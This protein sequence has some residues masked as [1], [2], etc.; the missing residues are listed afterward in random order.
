MPRVLIDSF[1]SS[2]TPAPFLCLYPINFLLLLLFDCLDDSQLGIFQRQPEKVHFVLFLCYRKSIF[3]F[4]LFSSFR[5]HFVATFSHSL[6]CG[7]RKK[8]NNLFFYPVHFFY[9][10][11]LQ[12]LLIC[13][14]F[15]AILLFYVPITFSTQFYQ[16]VS[17]VLSFNPPFLN[18]ENWKLVF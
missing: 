13:V 10:L 11:A 4:S 1:I 3:N 14:Y 2:F 6:G 15:Q 8:K 16:S 17:Y 12:K 7:W 5:A 18:E 9:F